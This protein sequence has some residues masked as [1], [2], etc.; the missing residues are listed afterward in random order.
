MP[1]TDILERTIPHHLMG[2]G[3]MTT[4]ELVAWAARFL[5]VREHATREA[6]QRL[7]LAQRIARVDAT[8]WSAVQ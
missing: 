8:R 5:G 6:M 2:H 1:M 3:P 4:E 7:A